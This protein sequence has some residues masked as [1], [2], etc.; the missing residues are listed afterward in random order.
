MPS[1]QK[2]LDLTG[3]LRPLQTGLCA[4]LDFT[5]LLETLKT[6]SE[7]TLHFAGLLGILQTCLLVTSGLMKL[8]ETTLT[9]YQLQKNLQTY[10]L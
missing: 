2:T 10:E 5:R 3:L 7:A 4:T 6:G 8:Q 9:G 1:L